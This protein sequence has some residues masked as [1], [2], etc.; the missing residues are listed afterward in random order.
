MALFSEDDSDEPRDQQLPWTPVPVIGDLNMDHMNRAPINLR[1]L[2]LLHDCGAEMTPKDEIP[3]IFLEIL[4][5]GLNY[6]KAAS[7]REAGDAY[8]NYNMALQ[9]TQPDDWTGTVMLRT[10]HHVEMFSHKKFST[11]TQKDL[12]M[13]FFGQVGTEGSPMTNVPPCRC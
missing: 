8:H 10:Q 6:V 11:K 13:D 12:I 9:L 3:L 5:L 1:A 2:A 7:V 4:L